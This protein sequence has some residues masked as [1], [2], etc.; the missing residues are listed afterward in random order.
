MPILY[1]NITRCSRYV[2]LNKKCHKPCKPCCIPPPKCCEP[3]YMP[4]D[5]CY[6][7][8]DRYCYSSNYCQPIQECNFIYKN[9]LDYTFCNQVKNYCNSSCCNNKYC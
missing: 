9:Q 6:R 3:C 4:C 8:C 2:K 5:P 1:N 7:K